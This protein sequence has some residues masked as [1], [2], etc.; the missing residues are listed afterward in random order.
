MTVQPQRTV[1][2]IIAVIGL[3]AF[4]LATVARAQVPAFSGAEGFGGAFTGSAPAGE[5]FSNATVYHVTTT[6][7]LLSADGK[8]APGT[9]RGAFI[10]AGRSQQNS[11]VVVVFDVG[12]VFQLTNGSLDIKTVNNIYI[13]GQTAPS[14][15][16]VYGDT[17]QITHSNNTVNSNVILRYMT[18][19]RGSATTGNED[20]LT[21]AGGSNDGSGSIGTNMII[22]HASTSWATDE[23]LSVANC[24]T[25]ITVQYSIIAD[26]LRSDHAYGSLI[27]TRTNANVTYAHNLYANN[28]S[29]N[30]RPGTYNGNTL[31]FDYRNNVLYNWK[32]RAGYTGGAS[33]LDTEHVNVNYVGNYLIAGPSTPAGSKSNTAFTLDLGGDPIDLHVYQNGNAIDADHGVNPGGVPNGSDTSWG[34]FAQSNDSTS[35]FP[36]TSKWA[37][38]IGLPG[39]AGAPVSTVAAPPMATQTAAGAYDQLITKDVHGYVGNSWWSRD[40]IDSRIINNVKTNTNPPAGVAVAAPDPTELA[41]LL[42]TPTVVR[43][44]NWDTDGDGMPDIWETAH[45]LNPNSAADGKADFDSDGYVN[46][47]EYLD[48]IGAFPAPGPNIFTGAMNNRYAQIPNWSLPFQPSRFDEVQIN[49]GSVTV[50][51]VGQHAGVLK[52][53]ASDGS[54]AALNIASGWLQVEDQLV[55]GSSL[56]KGTLKLSGG[57]LSTPILDKSSGATFAFTGGRLHA[58]TITFGV[59]NQGGTIAPGYRSAAVA[60][61]NATPVALSR[62]GQTHIEGNLTIQ[63]GAVEIELAGTSS[64]DKLIVDGQMALGGVLQVLLSDGFTPQVGNSFDIL[65][66]GNRTGAFASLQLPGLSAHLTWSATQLYSSGILSV[67][68]TLAGD[69]NQ[70]AA[71]T[72]ADIPVMLAALTDLAAYKISHTLT[73]AQLA[74]IGDFDGD[75]GVTNRDIQNLLDVVATQGGGAAAAVPEP[76]SLALLIFGIGFVLVNRR[77]RGDK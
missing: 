66:W 30:P 50:D 64:F 25:N 68:S 71:L 11:N 42:A 6:Q 75:G 24:N 51:A 13:A 54:V 31:N 21:F 4:D 44:A 69:F 48:E 23:D 61:Q 35:S 8:G 70:D 45:G 36:D 16:V 77:F 20:S 56:S 52:I 40:A 27:R 47:Q 67:V 58:G 1:C 60:I 57:D 17:T 10:N 15:V 41:N 5:W 65:D 32:D 43:A 9:L 72:A 63:S 46:V 28:L 59:V 19:R 62:I 33:E 37:A 12:G 74:L 18:F 29:R 7:D 55:I 22:D 73:D 53:A 2:P 38:P 49:N 3:F 34:M 39:N 76:S 14:P 26:S